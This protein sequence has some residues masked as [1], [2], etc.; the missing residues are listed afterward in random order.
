MPKISNQQKTAKKRKKQRDRTQ[1]QHS[2]TAK[3]RV[4]ALSSQNFTVI[5]N[6]NSESYF[7][8]I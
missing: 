4:H 7:G 2:T 5:E 8:A 3:C 6:L 1:K